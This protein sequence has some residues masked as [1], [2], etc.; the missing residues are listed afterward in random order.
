MLTEVMDTL[1]IIWHKQRFILFLFILRRIQAKEMK[2]ENKGDVENGQEI[3][4]ER[5]REKTRK[6]K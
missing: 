4:K 2:E 1:S 6:K 3:R 5:N